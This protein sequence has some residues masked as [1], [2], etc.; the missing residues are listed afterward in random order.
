ML[1]GPENK[2]IIL[3]ASNKRGI[4]FHF[5]EQQVTK[6]YRVLFLKLFNSYVKDLKSYVV[7]NKIEL[8]V[9]SGS[10]PKNWWLNMNSELNA[11]ESKGEIIQRV[12]VF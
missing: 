8:D 4:M 10:S 11:K 12:G 3:S 2:T 9:Y 1:V 7:E 6:R 5:N